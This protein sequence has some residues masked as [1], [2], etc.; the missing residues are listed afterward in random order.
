MTVADD[1]LI[2]DLFPSPRAYLQGLVRSPI[3]LGSKL[4]RWVRCE[5]V[6]DRRP[7]LRKDPEPKAPPKKTKKGSK[8]PA[9]PPAKTGSAGARM[10]GIAFTLIAFVLATD[11]APVLWWLLLIV[12]LVSGFPAAPAEEYV[13]DAQDET[14][15][16]TDAEAEEDDETEEQV[17]P[18]AEEEPAPAGP[19]PEEI[20]AR[21]KKTL[22]EIIEAEVAAG[23][24]G[25]G[26]VRGR[27]ARLVDILATLRMTKG[28]TIPGDWTKERLAAVVTSELGIKYRKQMSFYADGDKPGETK[29]LNEWGIHYDDLTEALGHTPRLP[30]H[31]VPDLTR[32]HPQQAPPQPG[33]DHPLLTLATTPGAPT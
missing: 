12:W 2:R 16:D 29:K 25:H 19:T 5:P 3:W 20:I 15:D 17:E 28:L 10:A 4:G 22:T 27:G 6:F 18:E 23:E 30:A 9:K 32:T 24:A 11:R 14:E 1:I 26:P 33:S 13:T 21:T 31:L 8:K 7:Q